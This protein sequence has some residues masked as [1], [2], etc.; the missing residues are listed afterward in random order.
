MKRECT[1]AQG[2]CKK[3]V[4]SAMPLCHHLSSEDSKNSIKSFLIHN[5]ITNY[6]DL[7]MIVIMPHCLSIHTLKSL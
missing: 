1:S 5:C 3:L 6:V 2:K 4:T 7:P